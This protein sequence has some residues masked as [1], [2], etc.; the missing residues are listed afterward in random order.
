M[1]CYDAAED[2]DSMTNY[3]QRTDTD[4][5]MSTLNL[6]FEYYR[7]TKGKVVSMSKLT[8]SEKHIS[9]FDEVY[10]MERSRSSLSPS[11]QSRAKHAYAANNLR[12][13][14]ES[15]MS[16][17]SATMELPDESDVE[18]ESCNPEYFIGSLDLPERERSSSLATVVHPLA[19]P[20]YHASY[21]GFPSSPRHYENDRNEGFP[22]NNIEEQGDATKELYGESD[23]LDTQSTGA[24]TWFTSRTDPAPAPAPKESN[25]DTEKE[26][27]TADPLMKDQ[28]EQGTQMDPSP[29]NQSPSELT[30]S[31]TESTLT[32]NSEKTE[33]KSEIKKITPKKDFNSAEEL[34]LDSL[35]TSKAEQLDEMYTDRNNE[36]EDNKCMWILFKI[37]TWTILV[38]IAVCVLMCGKLSV[39]VLSQSILAPVDISK[40]PIL[41]NGN[42]PVSD[43]GGASISSNLT[44]T[45]CHSYQVQRLSSNP[46][47]LGSFVYSQNTSAY[48]DKTVIVMWMFLLLLPPVIGLISGVYSYIR[49]QSVRRTSL[50]WKSVI[51]VSL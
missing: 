9:S 41:K 34:G 6:G 15:R 23:A 48:L 30:K 29:S 5:K 24:W 26:T 25:I 4:P 33:S 39:I 7:P 19:E 46:A 18:S 13:S 10:G 2:T 40:I 14:R 1:Q 42:L 45:A 20:K 27:L 22:E 8:D 3:S 12:L 36:V 38:V 49:W 44:K 21:Q 50:S 43:L 35:K 32:S 28:K 47:L 37:L 11:M 16:Q 51:V 31:K 17:V